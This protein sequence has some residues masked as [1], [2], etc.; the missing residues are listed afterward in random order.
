[1][2]KKQL[3]INQFSE[4]E[5][6]HSKVSTL[7][8][9]FIAD[10]TAVN[11][12][13]YSTWEDQGET[14]PSFSLLQLQDSELRAMH[15]NRIPL[16]FCSNTT[17]CLEDLVG[18]FAGD[19][20]QCFNNSGREY[21]SSCYVIEY[22]KSNSPDL[23]GNG[24]LMPDDQRQVSLIDR[25]GRELVTNVNYREAHADYDLLEQKQQLVVTNSG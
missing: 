4:Y 10:P 8:R 19:L 24:L 3:D 2:I 17:F 5:L 21:F 14:S 11:V 12:P 16:D 25:K 1:Q 9:R 22:E 23:Y 6:I 15:L 13:C 7:D 20:V 18:M